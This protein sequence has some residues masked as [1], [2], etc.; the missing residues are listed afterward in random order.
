MPLSDDSH[1]SL[2]Y[3]SYIRL[4][5]TK[6]HKTN[7]LIIVLYA[8]S[9]A[10]CFLICAIALPGFNPLGHVVAQFMMV[11]QRYT[12]NGFC[13]C[14]RRSAPYSSLLSAIHRYACI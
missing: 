14:S 10:I 12:L 1:A 5:E 6:A 7:N 2:L 11:W 8:Y 3:L 4:K 13:N 9:A